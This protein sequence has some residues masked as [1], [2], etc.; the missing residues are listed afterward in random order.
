M[1]RPTTAMHCPLPHRVIICTL[2]ASL[3]FGLGGVMHGA[4]D[5]RKAREYFIS[6][7]SLQQQERYPEA[8]LEFQESLRHDSSAVTMTAIARC[9]MRMAKYDRARRYAEAATA[10]NAEYDEAYE[11]LAEVLVS[12]GEYDKAVETFER[13]RASSP[14]RRQLETLARL[15]EPRNAEKAIGV[16]EVLAEQDPSTETL[17]KL[18]ELYSRTRDTAGLVR[19]VERAAMREPDDAGIGSELVQLYVVT[20]RIDEA[21]QTLHAW[22]SADMMLQEKERV[23]SSALMTMLN[24]STWTRRF[25]QQVLTLLKRV[26]EP[27]RPSWRTQAMCG[28]LALRLGET[29]L[30]EAR[31]TTAVEAGGADPD[32]PL[33][34]AIAYLDAEQH[35]AAFDM[36]ARVAGKHDR[37]ARFPY[38]MGVACLQME[39]D[40]ASVVL[41]RHAVNLDRNFTDAWVQLGLSFEALDQSDSAEAAY[42]A[43][44]RLDPDH[45]LVNNNYAYSL[46]MRGKDLKRARSMAWRAVQQYPSNA[47]YLDTYAWVLHRMGLNDEA[48]TYIERAIARGGNATHY[49]HHG[50]ILQSLGLLDM[51]VESWERALE[52]DPGRESVKTKLFRFR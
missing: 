34:I 41:F 39:K 1:I 4:Q 7:S 25:R 37:D 29:A 49:D 8:I 24:D 28:A 12:T 47:A 50:D 27:L 30:A 6:G 13:L 23:W 11:T 52:L 32:V 18:A 38:Y 9:Y 26:D 51:A 42:D 5:D 3:L 22:A 43:V 17:Y 21:T 14:T 40:S 16:Y 31:F 35:K 15:Y 44:L 2:W 36:L 10:M 48:R 19:T 20:G 33:Q 45:H 46:A